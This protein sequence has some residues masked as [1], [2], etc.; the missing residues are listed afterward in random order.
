MDHKKAYE[1]TIA[2]KL[3]ALPLPAMADAI[4]ARIETQLD[5]DL[6]TDEGGGIGPESP[7]GGN[8]IGRG[9]LFVFIA[10]LVMSFLIYKNNKKPEPVSRPNRTTQQPVQSP[11]PAINTSKTSEG[12]RNGAIPLPQNHSVD[13][14]VNRSTDSLLTAPVTVLPAPVDSAQVSNVLP[15]PVLPGSDTAPV[16]K[17]AR[18]VP[19]ITDNDYRIVPAKKDG[20]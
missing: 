9:G 18:G 6:P 20:S 13:P 15:P 2:S 14:P 8:W 16:K 5:I 7:S 3:E 10:A 11:L 1:Q 17:K 4:W 19:G 12:R